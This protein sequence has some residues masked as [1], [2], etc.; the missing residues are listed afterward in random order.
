MHGSFIAKTALVI[1]LLVAPAL[2]GAG[3]A[4]VPASPAGPATPAK[5]EKTPGKEVRAACRAEVKAQGVKGEARK[6]AVQGCVARERPDLAQR[7]TCRD[8][9]K[10]KALDGKELKLF[11]KT[12]MNGKG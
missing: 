11:V 2:A 6:T 12:C 10:A 8:E 1:G 3:F 9:G 4:Q 7:K 5:T